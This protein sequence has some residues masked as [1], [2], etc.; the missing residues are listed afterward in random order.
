MSI[1]VALAIVRFLLWYGLS[2]LARQPFQTAIAVGIA[3][4]PLG[5]FNVVLANNG[6]LAKRLDTQEYAAVIG[7]TLLSIVLATVAARLFEARPSA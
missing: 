7:A 4:V 6:L 2:R 3:L 1:G 5:E